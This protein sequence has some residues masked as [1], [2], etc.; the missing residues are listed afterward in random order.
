MKKLDRALTTVENFILVFAT[1]SPAIVLFVNVILRKFTMSAIVWAE[2]Y[3][4]FAIM[5]VV[6][7]GCGV[8]VRY[9]AHA[10]ITAFYDTLKGR[11]KLALDILVFLIFTAYAV[12]LVIYGIRFMQQAIEKHTISAFMM[13][14]MWAIYLAVPFGGAS[15][16]IRLLQGIVKTCKQYR[17]EREA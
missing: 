13:V 2:E 4:K 6:F 1:L 12:F 8:A 16:I 14:P 7:G 17:Q 11:A 3:S 5:W 10:K 15:V 9:G